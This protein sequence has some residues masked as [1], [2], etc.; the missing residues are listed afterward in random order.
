MGHSSGTFY[1]DSDCFRDISCVV[2]GVT[3]VGAHVVCSS[4]VDVQTGHS[5]V[6]F[7]YHIVGPVITPHVLWSWVARRGALQAHSG[8]NVSFRVLKL[9]YL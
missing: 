5:I 8:T 3:C 1:S 6:S 9:N 4:V 7:L 2:P